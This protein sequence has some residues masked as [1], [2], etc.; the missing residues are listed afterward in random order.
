MISGA[1]EYI[2]TFI[3]HLSDQIIIN[4]E[5]SIIDSLTGTLYVDENIVGEISIPLMIRE[6]P[7][8]GD[9]NPIPKAWSSTTLHT[10]GHSMTDNVTVSKVPFFET[11]NETGDTVYIASEV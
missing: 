5:L 3:G 10:K 6:E 7:Y 2:E 8:T 4:S 11:A 1:F 9:Y